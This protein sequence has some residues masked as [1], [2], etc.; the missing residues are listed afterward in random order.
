MN[1]LL[2]ETLPLRTTKAL[3]DFAVDEPLAHRYGS[4]RFP[5]RRITDTEFFVSDHPDPVTQVFVD[6]NETKGWDQRL[7]SD[8]AGNTWQV[9]IM[10]APVASDSVVSGINTGKRNPR[11]GALLENPADI[12]EDALRLAGRIEDWSALRAECAAADLRIAGSIDTSQSIRSQ[13]DAIAQS[14]G[15]IWWGPGQARLYP[16]LGVTGY[17]L[18]LTKMDALNLRPRADL[19]DTADILR[20][21]YDRDDVTGKPLHYIEFTANPQRFGGVVLELFLP[22]LRTPANAEAIG[23]PLLT[24]LAAKR[25]TVPFTTERRDIR[26]GQWLRLVGHPEWPFTGADP[27]LMTLSVDIDPDRRQ[28]SVIAETLLTT[29]TITVTSHSIA[30]PATSS[31]GVDISIRDGIAFFTFTDQQRIPIKDARA[32]LDGGAAKTTDARGNVSFKVTPG[33]HELA[34]E[35]PGFQAQS[36]NFDAPK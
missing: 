22:W 14:A 35:A 15:A 18:E 1:L 25:Y 19:Q 20:L 21:S 6:D 30:L 29:P 2:S 36:F 33:T 13:L 31:P 8:F 32:S 9:V 24:R 28:S 17:V 34:F 11:T 27:V 3:G 5:L 12:I 10:A 7:R 4:T 26:P 16:T 23:R